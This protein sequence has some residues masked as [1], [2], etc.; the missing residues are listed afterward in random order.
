[1]REASEM[2]GI[3]V[4]I[5]TPLT[6]TED[7]DQ[8]AMRRLT[9]YILDGGVT[10]IFVMGSCGEFVR[11]NADKWQKAVD[12]VMEE[13]AGGA[14]VFVGISDAGT[15][16]VREKARR[17]EAAGADA[18]VAT[19]PYYFAVSQEE[20][21]DFFGE[22]AA[23]TRVPLI[24]YNIPKTTHATIAVETVFEMSEVDGVLGIKDSSGDVDAL[25]RMLAR[26]RDRKDFLV[27]VGDE[28]AMLTGFSE[29]ADG[30]VPSTANVAPRLL[31][32]L[33]E[34]AD[35]GRAEEAKSCFDALVQLR[36]VFNGCTDNGMGW[37]IGRKASLELM[38]ICPGRCAAP[39]VR[40]TAEK[41]DELRQALRRQ[42]LID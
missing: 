14:P 5:A 15:R 26:F 2:R 4:P 38:G 23:A 37:L 11:M 6:D 18:V 7:V 36:D 25:R 34:A 33:F 19:P 20:M 13:T 31:A 21:V 1:M 10:G 29:G 9:R 30:G 12:A 40:L 16:L 8:A 24:L 3:M 27:Y 42:G 32:D 41:R 28:S 35:A 22:V 39:A 17:A